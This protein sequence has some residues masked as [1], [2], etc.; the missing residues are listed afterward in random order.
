MKPRNVLLM[1]TPYSQPRT[2]GI[3]RFAKEHAW[4]LMVA[5]RLNDNE[6]PRDYDGVLMTLR[7][8]PAAVRTAKRLIDSGVAIVDLT[9]ERPDIPLPRVVS[10][11][12]AI[13]RIAAAHFAERG[14]THFAWFSSGWSN[15][16]ALRMSGFVNGFPEGTKVLKWRSPKLVETI[17]AAPKPIAVLA[18]NDVDAARLVAA[19]RTA[20]YA[21]PQDVALLGIGNDPF[22]CENQAT[23]LSSV[24][25][26]LAR[27]AYEGATLL[28][29]L[30]SLTPSKRRL[31]ATKKPRLTKPDGVVARDSS[32]TL[33]H[34]N[35][36]IRDALIFIHAHL[37]KPF[38][39]REVAEGIGITRS[40]LDHLFT[41]EIHRS[42][43]AEIRRQRILRAQRLLRDP[44]VPIYLVA[45]ACGFCNSA[46]L[47][48]TFRR[49]TGLTPK[50]WRHSNLT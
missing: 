1:I 47:T 44:S 8:K 42:V 49:V 40:K 3:S 43:G 16:H 48:N 19:C 14:F 2:E 21:V 17:A 23:P 41:T 37:E 32:D 24:E 25:Q 50:A 31:A 29:K 20:G 15:V 26:N 30:M 12:E 7:D 36:I 9:I 18:Y 28:E 38:G 39:A 34:A 22:L 46:Y 11:H 13:G 6:D 27:N 35:P 45:R 33:A 5:D 10:D 4:N